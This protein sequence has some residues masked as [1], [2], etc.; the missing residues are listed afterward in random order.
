MRTKVKKELM[1]MRM[2]AMERRIVLRSI[3]NVF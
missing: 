2:M 3:I 1:P